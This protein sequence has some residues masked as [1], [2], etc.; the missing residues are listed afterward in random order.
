MT[1][2]PVAPEPPP[3]A[4]AAAPPVAPKTCVA[5]VRRLPTLAAQLRG[6][7]Q[8]RTFMLAPE[9]SLHLDVDALGRADASSVASALSETMHPW[10]GD[11]PPSFEPKIKAAPAADGGT[12]YVFDVHGRTSEFATCHGAYENFVWHGTFDVANGRV[13]SFTMSGSGTVTE[14]VCSAGN[15]GAARDVT[16]RYPATYVAALSTACDD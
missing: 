16:G 6:T 12:R 14:D 2:A 15:G 11:D 3:P 1:T 7:D 5:L 9:T 10:V 4:I 8:D 13:T